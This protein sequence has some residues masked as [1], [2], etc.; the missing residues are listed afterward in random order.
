MECVHVIDQIGLSNYM[1]QATSLMF[2]TVPQCIYAYDSHA[3]K[4][5]LYEL[6]CSFARTCNKIHI[7]VAQMICCLQARMNVGYAYGVTQYN[8]E[9]SLAAPQTWIV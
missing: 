8:Y 3:V 1:L 6:Q 7:F 2:H 5:K 4:N 9:D